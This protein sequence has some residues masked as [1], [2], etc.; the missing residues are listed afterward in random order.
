MH[1]WLYDVDK[2]NTGQDNQEVNGFKNV[3]V[4]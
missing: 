4:D 2:F 1:L 3:L